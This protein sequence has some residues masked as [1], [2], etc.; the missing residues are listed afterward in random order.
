MI[1]LQLRLAEGDPLAFAELY[2]A[3]A[4]RVGHYLIVIL[5]DADE[6]EEVLQDVFLRL[7]RSQRKLAG[8]ENLDAYVFTIARN[9]AARLLAGKSRRRRAERASLVDA[10]LFCVPPDNLNDMENAEI[11]AALLQRLRDEWREVLELKIYA[12][13]TFR[14]I[15]LATGTPQGTVATRYRAALAKMREWIGKQS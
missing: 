8:V 13:M 12:G 15:S 7:A 1:S 4:D 5:G 2:D 14:E 9:E 3:C 11:V 6:A 10:E